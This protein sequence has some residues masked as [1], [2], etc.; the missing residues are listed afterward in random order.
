MSRSF[1]ARAILIGVFIIS[2]AAVSTPGPVLSLDS[3]FDSTAGIKSTPTDSATLVPPNDL[4]AP[5]VAPVAASTAPH[6]IPDLT[7]QVDTGERSVPM[8]DRVGATPAK[9]AVDSA[10]VR[11]QRSGVPNAEGNAVI[12]S[13]CAGGTSNAHWGYYNNGALGGS[14]SEPDGVVVPLGAVC[15][16]PAQPDVYS[17]LL[18]ELG[19]KYFWEN[20]LWESTKVQF[21]GS[22]RAA[23]CFAKVFGA[24]VFGAG[25]CSDTDA[26]RMHTMLGD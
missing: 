16:N 6:P 14:I 11:A 10:L 15:I 25:G 7:P 1:L 19:H 9:V 2:G 21:G 12:L 24:T 8:N 17:S 4:D 3:T 26:Q 13:E 5:S 18:H 20:G 22:E 23:E